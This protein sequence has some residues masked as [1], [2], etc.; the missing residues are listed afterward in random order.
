MM[1]KDYVA[2]LERLD[3]QGRKL[4]HSGNGHHYKPAEATAWLTAVRAALEA[5]FPPAHGVCRDWNAIFDRAKT[6]RPYGDK[7]LLVSEPYST[8][9]IQQAIGVVSGAI[10][11]V[12]SGV[13]GRLTD[14]ARAETVSEVLAQADALVSAGHLIGAAVLAGGALETHL[15]HLCERNGLTP[16]G[17]GSI[18]KYDQAV[19]KARNEGA[20]EVYSATETKQV[21]AWGGVRNEAAHE[22]TKFN[23][24][25]EEVRLMIAG[26]RDFIARRS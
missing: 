20:I 8:A 21:T 1:E 3:A 13:L 18:S 26:V 9:A 7:G 16:A 4:P 25:P 24:S 14:A 2:L 11:L 5:G 15:L 19:A 10:E 12:K 6:H 17:A 23:R 22:P